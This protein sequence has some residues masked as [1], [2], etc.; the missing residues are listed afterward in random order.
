MNYV[1][2][3]IENYLKE[4]KYLEENDNKM[5]FIFTIHMNRIFEEDKKDKKKKKYIERNRLGE[6]ISHLSDFYHIFID[7]LNG[8]NIS[9][10]DIM[11]Y[12]QED[13]FKKILNLDLEFYKNIYEISTYINYDFIID[14]PDINQRNYSKS[15]IEY[16]ISEKNL[17]EKIK[18]CIIK[19]NKRENTEDIFYYI[20]KNNIM[21]PEDVNIISVLR[22][23]LSQL[24]KNNFAKYIFASE[25]DH[26]FSPLLF[27]SNKIIKNEENRNE[28]IFEEQD[29]EI[30]KRENEIEHKNNFDINSNKLITMLENNYIDKLDISQIKDF[31][32]NMK[33]NQ[34]NLL[35][36]L[37][38]PAMK[39][40]INNIR[41]HLKSN[42]SEKYFNNEDYIRIIDENQFFEEENKIHNFLNKNRKHVEIEIKKQEIFEKIE[43]MKHT[44][45]RDYDQFYELLMEDYYLI[46]LS[47]IAP[48][49][50]NCYNY[51]EDYKN[52][53][54]KMVSL[55]FENDINIY[56]Y[57]PIEVFSKKILWLESYSGIISIILN[58]YKD[59]LVYKADIYKDFNKIMDENE[60]QYEISNR[61]PKKNEE[62][63]SPF[64]FILESLLKILTSDY[65]LYEK[66][67]KQKFYDFIKLLKTMQENIS[68]IFN[69]LSI[70]SKE[71]HTIE[72]FLNIQHHLNLANKS[73]V[74]NLKEILIILS[75]HSKLANIVK[76]D[77]QKLNC[78]EL[79][80]NMKNLYNF[81]D[82]NL[83]DTENF[84]KLILNICLEEI[85]TISNYN[86]RKLLVEIVLKNPKIIQIS[87]PFF[88][89]IINK[90]IPIDIESISL[91]IVD[92]L[93]HKEDID[94]IEIICE[95][96]NDVL[97][98]IL[99]NIFEN[100]FNLFFE[101]ITSEDLDK[102]MQRRS[103]RKY[104]DYYEETGKKN[105]TLIMFDTS[106]DVFKDCLLT[107]DN[108]YINS[109]KEEEQKEKFKYE[110]ILVLYCV[111]YI[112]IYLYKC[113]HFAHYN[114]QEF[115]DFKQIM[116]FI[117]EKRNNFRKMIK[118]YILKIF[119]HI[120][121]RD[122]DEFK[123]Y[124]FDRHEI[125]FIGEFKDDLTSK[126]KTSLNYYLLPIEKYNDYKIIEKKFVD[127]RNND[128]GGGVK[129]FRDYI[130][131]NGIDNFYIISSNLIISKLIIPNYN[132]DEQQEFSKYSLF[133]NNLFDNNLKLSKIKKQLF[134]LFSKETEFDNKIKPKIMSKTKE[135]IDANLF[136]MLLYALRIC[137]QT[138]DLE[139]PNEYFYSHIISKNIEKI[140]KESCVPGN[141]LLDNIKVNNYMNIEHHL[142]TLDHDIGVYVCSCGLYYEIPPCGFPDKKGEN[143]EQ[144]RC[145]N[146]KEPIGYGPPKENYTGSHSMFIRPGHLRIF[147][148]EE[149]RKQ[150][151]DAYGDNE[152]GIPN[153]LLKEYKEKIIDPILEKSKFGINKIEK[154]YFEQT[155][156]TIR[157]LSIIGYRLLNFV[158]YS[159]IFFANC[160][161]FI[162]DDKLDNYIS[163]DMTLINMIETDWN[164]LKD[165]LQTKGVQNIQVFMNMIFKK[166]CELLCNCKD[167]KT[168][169]S[170]EKFELEIEKMLEEEYKNYE[171]YQKKYLEI[172]KNA[173]DLDINSVKSL[174][175]EIIDENEYDQKNF[176]FY[177]LLFMTTYP[178]IE[179]FKY[180]LI[181]IP[182]FEQKYPFLNYSLIEEN[183]FKNL[184]KYLPDFNKFINFMIDNYSYKISRKE[185]SKMILKEQEIYQNNQGGF[186]NMFKKFIKIWDKI[187]EYAIK[188]KCHPD[189]EVISLDENKT[190]DFYLNDNGEEGK[191]MYIAAA[192]QNF[193]SWQN[194]FLDKLI[195]KLK[196]GGILYHYVDNMKKTIDVQS[197]SKNEVLDFDIMNK[198]LIEKLYENSKRNIFKMENKVSY[199][200]YRQFIYDFDSMEKTLGKEVLRGKVKF[201]GENNLKFVTYCFE[202]FRGNKS[203]VFVDFINMYKTIDLNND[204]KQKIYDKLSDKIENNS[205]DLQK[206]LFSIQLLIYYLTQDIRSSKDEINVVI[207]GLP[208][209]V[210]LTSECI[211]F[212]KEQNFK[213]CELG[214]IYTY[215]ELL[216]FKT[217][218]KNLNSFYKKKIEE[219]NKENILKYFGSKDKI[220]VKKLNL[221][222]ACRK[223]ISRYLVSLRGDTDIRE[224]L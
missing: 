176:P 118:I 155:N 165:C 99:L 123:D 3:F 117:M 24:F 81:L 78:E 28:I 182:N 17:I 92:D 2:F 58:I 148:D 114:T 174:V 115:I 185:A 222:T 179:N 36:G 142:N 172:N 138:S 181:K 97:N 147:K 21:E 183:K 158:I 124:H 75:N 139:K 136:E 217:I 189:M 108:I 79:C 30:N 11:N 50:K 41:L 90:I 37:K 130:E 216:C 95:T 156:I 73:N 32:N 80:D 83:S 128:F 209:Y 33:N 88:S 54:K 162:S 161:G 193:I 152:E 197:A 94:Y 135:K 98:E 86:Y 204:T 96:K 61:S 29:E 48:N 199:Q 218:E 106:F 132:N 144:D 180:E 93:N 91:R 35:L 129:E 47:E 167:I 116:E 137:L 53:L 23:Y 143:E 45:I 107:L 221:A 168:S 194:N 163:K 175:L 25:K 63:N 89:I 134:F 151:F 166:L 140:L 125:K 188:Y 212:F 173:L 31:N 215:F 68:K 207:S 131:A 51:L 5:A 224:E 171:E 111:A 141:N 219:K 195:N 26:F 110:L 119:F 210:K 18:Y 10:I 206:I 112:K 120:N 214:A 200:N 6:T 109:Q 7:D 202:G 186:K 101:S 169:D 145:L 8:G 104:Y 67:E 150:E 43:E 72:E 4:K 127:F 70:H 65:D 220:M 121:G 159:H 14:I 190:L 100:K 49:F 85:K 9:F 44:N 62:I 133:V 102:N 198:C 1:K 74:E 164:I 211:K 201:N 177:K 196:N 39:N 12:N 122:Y 19:Q 71:I 60:I 103:F 16:L 38:L 203:S 126:K 27:N 40:I 57:K 76:N 77:D 105:P 55:R 42:I 64:F 205:N 15:L 59:I 184:I 20:L 154:K 22:K 178:S 146:C 170:R 213:V 149:H 192:L 223:L 187:K 46:F 160:L 82:E 34:I 52:I 69:E 191:G 208:E 113:I 84:P 13:L 153:M 66:I 87:Q 56:E 157:K